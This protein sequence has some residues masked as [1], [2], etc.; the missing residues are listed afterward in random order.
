M[1]LVSYDGRM[2]EDYGEPLPKRLNLLHIEVHAGRSTQATLL[3][4][5]CDT[6]ES[7]YLS[8]A[9]ADR[10]PRGRKDGLNWS[11]PCEGLPILPQDLPKWFLERLKAVTAKRAKTVIDHILKHG[12]ITTEEL[13]NLYG[14]DH[15]PRA[16]RCARARHTAGDVSRLGQPRQEHRGLSFR[17]SVHDSARHARR[18]KGLFKGIQ[19]IAR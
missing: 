7:L 19:E 15:P 3:G 13:K 12:H 1:Y 16:A 10:F 14:Y 18:P 6:Y 17:R 5:D 8:P 9:L 4:R 2:V 11:L